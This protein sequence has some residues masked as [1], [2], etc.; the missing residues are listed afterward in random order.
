MNVSEI[1]KKHYF[2]IR[3]NVQ[4]L[5]KKVSELDSQE[6]LVLDIAP[7][8][9]KGAKEFFKKATVK[10]LDINPLSSSDYIADLCQNNKEIIPDNFFDIIICTEVLE[11]TNNPFLA[12]KELYRMVKT[13]G[14]VVVST[15]FNFRI[16]RPLP[17]NWRFTEHG[18]KILFSDFN[19]VT[20]ESLEDKNRFL[21]PIQYSVIAKK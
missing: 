16:H 20:I 5:I 13:G 1:D 21:M 9:H 18:L 2:A 10:T 14:S 15:P 8:I 19:S 17:D 12:V 3:N 6:I 11:H 7:E 4:N